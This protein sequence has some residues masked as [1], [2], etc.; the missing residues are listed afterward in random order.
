MADIKMEKSFKL[1]AF[2]KGFG[3]AFNLGGRSFIRMP[4]LKSGF[5]RDGVALRGDWERVGDDIRAS[6]NQ[7]AREQ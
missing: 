1:G 7:A 2:F 4:D 5:E 3:S 6:M